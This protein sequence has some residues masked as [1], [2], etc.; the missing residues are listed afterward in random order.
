[1]AACHA[2]KVMGQSTVLFGIMQQKAMK[3]PRVL[4]EAPRLCLATTKACQSH[5][6]P[7]EDRS[8]NRSHRSVAV[9]AMIELPIHSHIKPLGSQNCDNDWAKTI[10]AA[11]IQ[12]E[13]SWLEMQK[14]VSY[15]GVVATLAEI[16]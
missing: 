1:M 11:H 6:E 7:H 16:L 10:Q 4:P 9:L 3:S 14:T 2:G 15:H 8:K 12:D 5:I 13:E